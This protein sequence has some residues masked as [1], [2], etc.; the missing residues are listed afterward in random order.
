MPDLPGQRVVHEEV[1]EI[2]ELAHRAAAVE[3]ATVHGGDAGAV[4]AAVF[5]PLQRLDKGGGRFMMPRIPTIPHMANDLS[6]GR[7][8][9]P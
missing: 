5:E 1:G 3:P 9:R 7:P 6:S 2:D 8:W 4:I